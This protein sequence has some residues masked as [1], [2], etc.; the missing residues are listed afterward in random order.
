MSNSEVLGAGVIN[1]HPNTAITLAAQLEADG[2]TVTGALRGS[3][4]LA[5]VRIHD[6]VLSP[7]QVLNNYNVERPLF[8]GPV[9]LT[10]QP[11]NQ[12]AVEGGPV[13]FA[14]Q[15]SGDSPITYQWF[16]NGTAIPGAVENTC[17]IEEV[18]LADHNASFAV[19]ATNVVN[20]S[21]VLSSSASLS[22]TPD[23]TAPTLTGASAASRNL[24][25]D[26]DAVAV[27]FSEKINVVR[28]NNAANYT[29]SGP[30][31]LVPITRAKIDS[32]GRSVLLSTALLASGAIG[33]FAADG[34]QIDAVTFGAQTNNVS[35]GRFAT[36]TAPARVTS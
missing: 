17:A 27:A 26:L 23:T 18:T 35:E 13:T 14:A 34:T 3:L 24:L 8:T 10:L 20:S 7:A 29:L 22:V 12:T 33:L 28:A 1:T 6:G 30:A 15:A 19:I 32:L 11:V 25:T 31:G 16:R 21:G 4:F 9:Q 5:K 36:W 2:V